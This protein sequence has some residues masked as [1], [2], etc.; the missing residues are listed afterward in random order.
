MYV[1]DIDEEVVDT[2]PAYNFYNENWVEDLSKTD[3]LKN[4][5]MLLV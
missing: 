5:A 2:I 3:I 4:T 1:T